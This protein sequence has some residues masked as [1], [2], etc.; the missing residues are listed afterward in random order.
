MAK[1]RASRSWRRAL[2]ALLA[3]LLTA[4][5]LAGPASASTARL[6]VVGQNTV[7]KFNCQFSVS[8]VDMVHG[9]VTG[10][11]S[12]N[13]FPATLF[14]S[15]VRNEIACALDDGSNT[16]QLALLDRNANSSRVSGSMTVVVPFYPSY[17]LC[18]AADYTTRSGTTGV[19]EPVCQSG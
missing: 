12:G 8:N 4:A 19:T 13:A 3:L 10:T 9:T 2:P 11:I 18:G 6:R 7:D 5:A 15:I 1:H 16:V 17:T 14:T